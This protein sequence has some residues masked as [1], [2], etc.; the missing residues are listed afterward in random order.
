MIEEEDLNTDTFLD[1]V[2]KTYENRKTY[3]VNQQSYDASG[4]ISKIIETILSVAKK[5]G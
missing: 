2:L 1:I 5:W 3:S 4:S